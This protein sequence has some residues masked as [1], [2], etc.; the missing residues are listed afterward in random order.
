MRQEKIDEL[1]ADTN[2]N[3]N[4]TERQ[5]SNDKILKI[6]LSGSAEDSIEV[7][8]T[9]DDFR[10]VP[11][12]NSLKLHFGI[13]ASS[14]TSSWCEQSLLSFV[15]RSESEFHIIGFGHNY[16]DAPKGK[17]FYFKIRAAIK[18]LRQLPVWDVAFLIDGYDT[19]LQLSASEIMRIYNELGSP[20]ILYGTEDNCFPPN[21]KY[22]DSFPKNPFGFHNKFL[23]A[24][25]IIGRVGSILSMFKIFH[26]DLDLANTFYGYKDEQDSAH[27][28]Y[29]HLKTKFNITLD[30]ESKLF[31]SVYGSGLGHLILSKSINKSEKSLLVP[32]VFDGNN[33][34]PAVIHFNGGDR[35][36]LVRNFMRDI[37]YYNEVNNNKL[38]PRA[39]LIS[40]ISNRT[41]LLSHG[42]ERFSSR[43]AS[44][45]ID[46][47]NRTNYLNAC[48]GIQKS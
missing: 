28:A 42:V 5:E 29:V 8:F 30:Y 32:F 17:L 10:S 1:R 38:A 40:E 34:T 2:L 7:N 15:T 31:Y 4:I 47:N 39:D 27:Y 12:N 35:K 19:I 16:H 6:Q 37:G 23:N 41:F 11:F 26:F 9:V 22:C 33:K 14:I 43:L 18:F 20:E 24:G 44:Q 45:S 3:I 48:N 46:S 13:F 36:H 21:I 25:T